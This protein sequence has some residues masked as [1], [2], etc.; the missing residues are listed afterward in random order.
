VTVV[1]ALVGAA[2]FGV[3]DF[4]GGVA[5]RRVSPW[6]VAA[7]GQATALVLAVPT[8]LLA[9]WERVARGDVAWSLGSG[10]TVAIGLG[11]FYSAMARGAV[12]LVVPLTAVVSATI[13]VVYALVRGERPGAVTFGGIVL[14]LVAI[15]VVSAFPGA[16]APGL[17]PTSSLVFSL[18]AGLC[19]GAFIV[20]VSHAS[21]HAGLWPIVFSRVTSASGLVVL[22]FAFTGS[23]PD[24]LLD[25]AP[26]C[27]AVG[28]LEAAG[29]VAL[30]LALQRGPLAVASAL[31]A[32]YPVGTVLLAMAFLRERLTRHQLMGVAMALCSVAL[33]STQ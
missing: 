14:A 2:V 16:G 20:L 22:A 11:L 30:L 6:R 18:T 32:L 28:V 26:V 17:G 4:L 21:D 25:A 3:S 9:S 13:P 31:L 29:I 10:V 15:A 24:G 27:V 33:I 19:F 5:S 8:A 1:L 23:R 12:S 7:I